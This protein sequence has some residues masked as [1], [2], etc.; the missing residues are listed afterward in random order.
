M[1]L[2]LM[3][4]GATTGKR[5]GTQRGTA[6][7]YP[8]LSTQSMCRASRKK[9]TTALVNTD[10]KREHRL[11][12]LKA[13]MAFPFAWLRPTY[14]V[15]VKWERWRHPFKTK[16]RCKATQWQK[17]SIALTLLPITATIKLLAFPR[18]M[19]KIMIREKA[20]RSSRKAKKILRSSKSF[21]LLGRSTPRW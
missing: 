16:V 21:K 1:A 14:K 11:K 20:S 4:P 15:W 7:N 2:N 10:L 6:W 17:P 9:T 19:I 3:S 12:Q 18:T 5:S 13:S 8:L